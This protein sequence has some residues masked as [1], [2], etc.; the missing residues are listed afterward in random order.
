MNNH[1]RP[2]TATSSGGEGRE[3]SERSAASG[4]TAKAKNGKNKGSKMN[5]EEKDDK[6]MGYIQMARMG[7]QELVNA[8]IRPP[9]ADYKVR[10]LILFLLKKIFT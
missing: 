10:F 7:Y 5:K 8:I 3:D 9:R 1:S 6:K 4:T 2:G